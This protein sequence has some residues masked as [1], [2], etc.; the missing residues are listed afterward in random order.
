MKTPARIILFLTACLF[1][2]SCATLVTSIDHRTDDWEN[3]VL[4]RREGTSPVLFYPKALPPGSKV[5]SRS[6][7]WV[8]DPQDKAAFFVPGEPCGGLTSAAWQA[9]SMKAV[10]KSSKGWQNT[11]NTAMVVVGWP[12][13]A[14][15]FAVGAAASGMSR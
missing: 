9:E 4:W 8:V 2:P 3:S 11:R 6:A 12:A 5:D 1:L 10:N 14:G 7:K 15:L 13:L